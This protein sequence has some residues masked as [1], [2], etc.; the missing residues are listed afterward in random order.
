[1]SEPVVHIVDDDRS[2]RDSAA[3]LLRLQGLKTRTFE[4]AD[5]F[6][7]ALQPGWSGCVLLDLKMPG[8]TGLQLQAEL[9]RRGVALPVVI[10][11]AHGDVA[12]ARAALKAGA[13]DFLEKPVDNALLV[14]VVRG[15]LAYDA[16]LRRSQAARDERARALARL[17]ARERQVLAHVVQGQP[18]R[19]V[20]RA[21]GISPRTVEVYKARMMEK[22]GARSLADVIRLGLEASPGGP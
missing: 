1:M 6:L 10:V 5:A 19:E 15:A 4:S 17:T 12:T 18:N 2:V 7:A 20:A 16:D 8:M 14:D 21:L 9:A 3:V 11:T 22:L 13:L